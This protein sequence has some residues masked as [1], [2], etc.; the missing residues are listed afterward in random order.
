MATLAPNTVLKGSWIIEK[1]LGEGACAIVYSVQPTAANTS[2]RDIGYVAKVVQAPTGKG[3]VLKQR[4]VLYNLLYHEYML[5]TGHFKGFGLSPQ[6]PLLPRFIY[7]EEE[8]TNLG[9]VRFLVMQRLNADLPAY[10]EGLTAA[11]SRGQRSKG[12]GKVTDTTASLHNVVSKL[13][14]QMMAGLQEVHEKG[15]VFVDVKPGNFMVNAGTPAPETP[16]LFF[17]DFALAER[18]T[19]A[20]MGSSHRPNLPC[21]V[22]KGTPGFMSVAVQEGGQPSRRDDVEAAVWVLLSLLL[23]HQELPWATAASPQECLRLKKA[24]DIAALCRE[25]DCS[26]VSVACAVLWLLQNLLYIV[27]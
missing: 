8:T 27:L 1:K 12:K 3:A 20:T 23:P 13:G 6:F 9:K 18:Y 25:H 5:H 7:G 24:C 16:R 2:S 22:P 21:A 14:V 11:P 19:A 15:F 17:I 4:T 10:I 26:E